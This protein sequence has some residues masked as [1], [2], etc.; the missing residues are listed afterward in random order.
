MTSELGTRK[1]DLISKDDA[2]NLPS[3]RVKNDDS[4]SDLTTDEQVERQQKLANAFRTI[5]E[6]VTSF[7]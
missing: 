7:I 2:K 3:K 6:V 4:S 5:I 1:F